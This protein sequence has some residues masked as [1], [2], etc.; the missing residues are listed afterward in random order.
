MF[1][2][3]SLG[4]E[5]LSLRQ[6]IWSWTAFFFFGSLEFVIDEVGGR[7]AFAF[8]FAGVFNIRCSVFL[9]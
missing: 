5:C 3:R 1:R 6:H 2:L 8:A 9:L 4:G 7:S